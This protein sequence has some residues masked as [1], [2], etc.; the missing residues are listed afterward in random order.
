MRCGRWLGAAC[1]AMVFAAC[2][3]ASKDVT[4]SGDDRLDDSAGAEAQAGG[5]A[6]AACE[7]GT[8][9]L[10][11]LDARTADPVACVTAT[12]LREPENCEGDCPQET[13]MTGRTTQT[14]HL[15]LPDP[16]LANVRL[17]AV[18]ENYQQSTRGPSPIK[19]GTMAEIEMIPDDGFVLKFVDPEG[20]YLPG[21]NVAFKQGGEVIA[22]MK[23]NDLANVWFP[24]RTP[25][26]GEPV[27][28]EADG[29]SP[30]TVA[31]P[32]ELGTD[33]NTVTLNR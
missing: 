14:G 26:A 22:Q 33:G 23:T 29:F 12:L 3:T 4:G 15:K 27:T 25:F 18:A 20:N 11:L 8:G 24:S 10:V 17:F 6:A 19:P 31:G 1:A 28:I 30:V 13:V 5:G 21:V 9:D 16:N 2:A 32:E 7:S